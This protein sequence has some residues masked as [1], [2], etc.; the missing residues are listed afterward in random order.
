MA[1]RGLGIDEGTCT[2]KAVEVEKRAGTFV[3]VGAASVE[4]EASG[5][6]D[7][8]ALAAACAA[9]GIKSKNPIASLTGKDLVIRY[10]Q[11][12]SVPDWQLRKIME[13]EIGEIQN[14]SGDT[15]A[16]DFNLLPV[17]SDLSSD[18]LVLLAL[19]REERVNQRTAHLKEAR[20]GV[21]HFSPNA[22]ALFHAFRVFGPAVDGDVVVASIGA[23]SSDLCILRD[24]DLLYAR[25]VNTG[26]DVLND[27]LVE[28]FNV[29]AGKAEKLKRDFGDLRPRESRKGLTPQQEK[30]SYAL[31]GAA[32]RLFSLIQSTIQF[33]KTQIQLNRLEPSKIF[34]TGGTASIPGLADYIGRNTE[35][36]VELFDPLADADLEV[37]G[38][39]GS[40]ELTV[41]L[42][43][44][45]MAADPEAYSVEVLAAPMRR[46]R[47]FQE[48][49]LFT[50]LAV[51]IVLIYL[52]FY[53][54]R[55][56][57]DF[58]EATQD[59]KLAI[60]EQSKRSANETKLER[61]LEERAELGVRVEMLEKKKA[62]GEGLARG[63]ESLVRSLPEDLWIR[64][65]ELDF[66]ELSRSSRGQKGPRVPV[67]LVEGAGKSRAN[68]SVDESYREF[69]EAMRGQPDLQGK[70]QFT[71]QPPTQRDSFDFH[72]QLKYLLGAAPADEDTQ[73]EEGDR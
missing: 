42:G 67:V 61:L 70:G 32:G 56:S 66:E 34:L 28:Q 13:F 10:H 36:P 25:S 35:C 23:S 17:A 46:R 16:A 51:A 24:G 68:R 31:E 63:L 12:P 48:R 45:V 44:A 8:A 30:V 53:F 39:A 29:S 69:V 15:M 2:V 5:S 55:T 14:Q 59:H 40:L 64:K 4:A 33:A 57:A 43:L 52:G 65:I 49:H 26:G 19:T 73:D 7:A 47:E 18:D 62:A 1:T 72:L 60:A 27:A 3:P 41:A 9:A 54:V 22:V 11:V 50:V 6:F 71:D 38:P 21:R 58:E 37:Q 20:L